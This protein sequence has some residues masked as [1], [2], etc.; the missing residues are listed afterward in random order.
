VQTALAFLFVLGVLITVHEY[1]HYWVARRC[2]VKVL[3][4]SV[5]FGKALW[6]KRFSPDGTEWVLA[7]FPL[8]G[9]VKM[10][11]EREGQV[12]L[13]ERHQ[14]FNTQSLFKRSMIVL[15]G[16]LSNF[17]LAIG[18]FW[19]VFVAGT[20]ELRPLISKP[21]A[22]T[23]ASLVG[24][25]HG[26]RIVSINGISV[27]TW[28][29]FRWEIVKQGLPGSE[30]DIESIGLDNEV[31]QR[32]LPVSSS[33][34]AGADA[35]DPVANLGFS[36]YRPSIPAVVDQVMS[37]SP[38]ALAGF[39]A[40]DRIQSVDGAQVKEWQE[41]VD[42]IR[43]APNRE[44]RVEVLRSGQIELLR[45]TPKQVEDRGRSVVRIGLQVSHE[46]APKVDATI[47]VKY[48]VIEA[49]WHAVAETADKSIFTLQAFGRMLTGD[50]SWKNLSGP[51]TIA[52][53]AGQSARLG[54]TYYL[55]FMALVS[56][57]LGVLNLLPVPLLDGGHLLYY[58]VEAITRRP[59][60]ERLQ[61][62]GQQIGLTLL[63]GLMAFAFYND[64][65]RLI[66]G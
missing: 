33:D 51:V 34:V 27:E 37:D 45:V 9:Y 19:V 66:S 28:Q 32:K 42:S 14:A 21:L 54:I 50:L 60:S 11:D 4:F 12:P 62:I 22:G 53:Y 55:Q 3:R 65:Q 31:H 13:E 52:E 38:A 61:E 48:G 43:A 24:F 58:A 49:L 36:L 40:G 46:G 39:R 17:A 56:I 5:G 20:Q 2:G 16:P 47:E 1:G 35:I 7:V 41:F 30:L 57:S 8:G 64:I 63:I 10:L 23:P 59:L 25:S 18:L 6:S 15:A 26:E 29:D 44:L